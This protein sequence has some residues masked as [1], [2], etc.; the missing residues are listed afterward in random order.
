MS[1]DNSNIETLTKS[2]DNN[3]KEMKVGDYII[4]KT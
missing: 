3:N 1:E 4:K 2:K